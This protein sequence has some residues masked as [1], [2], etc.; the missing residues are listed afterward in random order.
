MP[1]AV[2]TQSGRC[3]SWPGALCQ[4]SEHLRAATW[5]ASS[6][7]CSRALEGTRQVLLRTRLR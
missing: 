3:A 5:R 1:W 4:L 2:A 7:E 6:L